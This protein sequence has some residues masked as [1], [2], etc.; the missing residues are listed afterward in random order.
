[1]GHLFEDAPAGLYI[2][3]AKASPA[4]QPGSVGPIDRHT[5][6]DSADI[7]ALLL[8]VDFSLDEDL[9]FSPILYGQPRRKGDDEKALCRVVYSD[10]DTFNP[11]GFRI[12]PT[13]TVETSAGRYHA[14][15]VLSKWHSQSDVSRVS[16]KLSK[17]HPIDASSGI[18]TKLL[19]VPE[20]TN[21]KYE[22]P[23]MVTA[24][25]TGPVYTLDEIAAIAQTARAQAA[26]RARR[27]VKSR[28]R[29]SAG[30]AD[31]RRRPNRRAW[32]RQR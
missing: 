8:D 14:Y 2:D 20:S 18:A 6:Y 22:I 5:F 21:T 11:E 10:A 23:F 24:E 27:L 7:D 1:M 29:W 15:W 12:P 28:R 13:F 3:L 25:E 31:R 19:R 30:R 17:A 9:Y 26:N 32:R 16:M 4:M